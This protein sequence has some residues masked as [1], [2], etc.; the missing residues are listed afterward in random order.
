MIYHNN[1]NCYIVSQQPEVDEVSNIIFLRPS[2]SELVIL[3]LSKNN[4]LIA[5][6]FDSGFLRYIP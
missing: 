6:F 4:F 5:T 2:I 3:N 1:H